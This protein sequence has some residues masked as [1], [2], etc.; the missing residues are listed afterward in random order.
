M[1]TFNILI[2]EDHP[3]QHMYLQHLFSELGS[4]NLKQPGMARKRWS[5][6]A[7]VTSTWC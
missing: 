7:S 6:C 1:K 3:F 4:F 2:V 5:A